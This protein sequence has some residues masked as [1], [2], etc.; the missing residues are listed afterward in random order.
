M[1]RVILIPVLAVLAVFQ[2][3]AAGQEEKN[4]ESRFTALLYD[5]YKE[6]PYVSAVYIS[7]SLLS[8]ASE[9]GGVVN[10][11]EVNINGVDVSSLTTI[12]KLKKLYVISSDVRHTAQ[13]INNSVE[14]Y[15]DKSG[16]KYEELVRVKNMSDVVSVYYWSPDAVHVGEFL[17]ISKGVYVNQEDDVY[18]ISVVQ[19][20]AEGLKLSDL[21]NVALDIANENS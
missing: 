18:S 19:F 5:K 11:S 20:E 17:M 16:R 9:L 3:F 15:I 13:D 6:A 14:A 7:E 8:L 4:G 21:V 10:F 12:G 1:K 2:G